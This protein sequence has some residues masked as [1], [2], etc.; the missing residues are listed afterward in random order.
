M[1]RRT[2][3]KAAGVVGAAA[4]LRADPHA[5]AEQA[6]APR[7]TGRKPVIKDI[8]VTPVAFFDMP[9]RHAWGMHS[10]VGTRNIVELVSADGLV[11]LGEI[12]GGSKWADRLAKAA[13]VV[14]GASPYDINAFRGKLE[15]LRVYSVIETAC[16]DM[17]GK[18]LGARVCDLLGGAVRDP[19]P[20][21]AYLFYKFDSKDKRDP[22]GKVMSPQAMVKMTRDWVKRWGFQTLKLKGGVLAPKVEIATM[23]ALREAFPNALLR[24]DPNSIWTVKES[25]A[26][27]KALK[28]VGLE[29]LED[30]CRGK[31]AMAAVRKAVDV[32]LSTNSGSITHTFKGVKEAVAA[33][34]ID[35]M[36]G[37]HHFWEGIGGV[38][39]LG[40]V[41]R[42]VGWSL[43]QHSNTH[44]GISM[45]AMTHVGA[46]TPE[47]VHASDTHYPWQVDDVIK[48]GKLPIRKGAI[49]VPEGP[50]L[51]VELDRDE[52]ARLHEHHKRVK[53]KITRGRDLIKQYIPD[54]KL[55]YWEK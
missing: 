30:P 13:D 38:Y 29:Y 37:D 28:P 42:S 36:L 16:W 54:W 39:R 1:N 44:L 41:C 32:P 27:A 15:N 19:V 51:G 23:K 49:A 24:I 5:V 7:P 53:G 34:C 12:Y 18:H 21:A 14:K 45:A 35:V 25:I 47:L 11:G 50:G 55:R 3:L 20:F 52:L 46:A 40:T 48:G 33:D 26:V 17:I 43:S 31:K 22:W 4:A 10:S 2:L 8:R 6:D 9:V